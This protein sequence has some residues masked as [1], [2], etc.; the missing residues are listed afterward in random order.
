MKGLSLVRAFKTA[1]YVIGAAVLSLAGCSVVY[2]GLG[3][4]L[5]WLTDDGKRRPT[6][7]RTA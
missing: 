7:P 5:A 2:L 3:F 4:G 1:L 6:P